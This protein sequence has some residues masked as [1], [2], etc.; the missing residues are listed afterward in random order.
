MLWLPAAV[1]V[2][3]GFAARK[4]GWPGLAAAAALC[5]IG[6]AVVVKIASDDQLQRYDYRA[7]SELLE[8][9]STTRAIVANPTNSLTPFA[10]YVPGTDHLPPS[11]RVR[12]IVFVGMHSQD[13]STRARAFDPAFVPRVPGFEQTERVDSGLYTLIT[14]QAPRATRVDLRALQ[15]ARLGSDEAALLI[16]R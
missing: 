10:A 16:Q 2:A 14:L 1:A 5:A 12:E 8:P 3:A 15:D 4:A 6:I 9:R 7:V 13:E 11:A